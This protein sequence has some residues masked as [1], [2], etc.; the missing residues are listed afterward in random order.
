MNSVNYGYYIRINAYNH[1]IKAFSSATE[2]PQPN[3]ILVNEGEGIQFIVGS[4]ILSEELKHHAN[5]ENG[6]IL[7]DIRGIYLLK[8]EDG[9][10]C[11]R[12]DKELQEELACLLKPQ[13]TK[14]EILS[15]QIEYIAMM[16][17]VE[18][19]E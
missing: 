6:L 9:V 14:Y 8:Y 18:L 19:E 15:A 13:P 16:A 5:E 17:D 10:I 3:D 4:N 12:S 7:F 11:K 2:E 1:I